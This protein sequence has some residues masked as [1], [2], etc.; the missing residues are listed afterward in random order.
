MTTTSIAGVS[1]KPSRRRN[2]SMLVGSILVALV[3][4]A[5][6]IS[7]IWTPFDPYQQ[8]LDNAHQGSSLTHPMGTDRLGR[9]V[10]SNILYGARIT[11]LVG[12][13]AVGIALLIGTPL[14]IL[15]GMRRGAT[16]EVTMRFADILLAFPALLLAIMFAAVY[17]PGTGSAMVAIGIASIPGF[18]RVARSGTL[19]VM[20]TEY[21]LAARASSQ[22]GIRVAIRHVLPNI[23]GMVV[24]QCSVT[25]ALAV[26]AEAALSFLGL[27]TQPPTASWGRMLQESQQYLWINPMLAVWPGIAIAIAVMGFN[28]LGDGLRDRFDPKLNGER[29]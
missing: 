2:T 14:G 15:A 25:F 19:Q 24:V 10:F 29:S 9:D 8:F 16:E 22:P 28:M 11:L 18:A 12:L 21:V 26:L 23:A 20:S 5:A 27:G 6:V 17:G 3:V 4:A 1:V 13:V 7:F